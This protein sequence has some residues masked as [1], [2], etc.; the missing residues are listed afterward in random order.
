MSHCNWLLRVL[1]AVLIFGLP[2]AWGQIY[3][4]P[5]ISDSAVVLSNFPSATT[6]MLLLSAP[7]EFHSVEPY[8]RDGVKYNPR[9]NSPPAEWS[10]IIR[11]VAK[12]QMIPQQLIHAVISA[13]SNYDPAAVSSRGAIGLMQVMP[14]TAR[15]FGIED[16]RSPRANVVAGASYLRFLLNLFES[17]IELTVAAYNAGELAV[18]KAGRKVPNFPETQAYV[19]RVMA[20]L[21]ASGYLLL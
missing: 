15:R 11:S 14:S 17:D 20:N 18:L 6:P 21:K 7:D 8:R 19:R 12:E 2:S 4:G 13:E 1:Q 16:I 5:A 3:V 10:E 9:R